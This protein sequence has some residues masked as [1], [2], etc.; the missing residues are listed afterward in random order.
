MFI[1]ATLL[2]EKIT[3]S[4]GPTIDKSRFSSQ[5][6]LRCEKSA[7][8]TTELKTDQNLSDEKIFTPY[9]RIIY[10]HLLSPGTS[11]VVTNG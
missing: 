9:H 7:S 3:Y 10:L 11:P 5:I 2:N 6:C 1:K 4:I 8:I